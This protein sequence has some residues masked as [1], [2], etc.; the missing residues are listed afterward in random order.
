MQYRFVSSSR[1]PHHL[2]TVVYN[3][4]VKFCDNV[5]IKGIRTSYDAYDN[6]Q[7]FAKKNIFESPKDLFFTSLQD[8]TQYF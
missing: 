3:N 1:E 4:I 8:S 5:K 6:P 2:L 7:P